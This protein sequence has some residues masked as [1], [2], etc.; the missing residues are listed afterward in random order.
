MM[1]NAMLQT[2]REGGHI[3]RLVGLVGSVWHPKLQLCLK[4][5]SYSNRHSLCQLL[6]FWSFSFSLILTFFP[7]YPCFRLTRLPL[8]MSPYA[9]ADT[10]LH[11]R[12][13]GTGEHVKF[14]L[15]SIEMMERWIKWLS[16]YQTCSLS[17]FPLFVQNFFHRLLAESEHCS[18]VWGCCCGFRSKTKWRMKRRSSAVR[19]E[20]DWTF[21][22]NITGTSTVL[23]DF[24]FVWIKWL[25]SFAYLW[26][27]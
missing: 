23:N 21:G 26:L 6:S 25:L 5:A 11:S 8:C 4:G 13:P 22:K 12:L 16:C 17:F 7:P 19:G 3:F 20:S 24:S 15:I 27:C 14:A 1:Q 2:K 10:P 9:T 18:S